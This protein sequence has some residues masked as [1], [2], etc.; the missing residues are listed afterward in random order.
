MLQGPEG[1]SFEVAVFPN[2]TRGRV[3]NFF[4]FF[5]FFSKKV[6]TNKRYCCIIK[7]FQRQ[8]TKKHFKKEV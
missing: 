7:V 8:E 5:E 3:K 4:N 2:C 6:L 1:T